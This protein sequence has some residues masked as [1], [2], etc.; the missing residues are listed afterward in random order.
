M[1][2]FCLKSWNLLNDTTLTEKDVV[3]SKDEQ[4]CEGCG[5]MCKII[6]YIKSSKD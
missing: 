2:E 5:K 4:Y 3:L 6:I 1:A